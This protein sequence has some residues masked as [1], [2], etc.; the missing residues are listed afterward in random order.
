VAVQLLL[1]VTGSTR[2]A[3]FDR[4]IACVALLDQAFSAL[5]FDY[6]IAAFRSNG[7]EQNIYH[8]IKRF[9]DSGQDSARHLAA[10]R[11]FGYT[12][13]GPALRHARK[14]LIRRPNRQ[15]LLILLTDGRPDDLD[16]YR[17]AYAIADT[18]KALEEVRRAGVSDWVLTL[19]P[20]AGSYF[21]ELVAHN[22]YRQIDALDDLPVALLD[23]VRNAT[24]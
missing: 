13:M 2:G 12:R 17:G 22:R 4:M 20:L 11:P 10:L 15:H 6:A 8:H 19:D 3:I 14:A 7:R 16:G 18:R 1:D 5:R 9:D 24:L 23:V 21:G